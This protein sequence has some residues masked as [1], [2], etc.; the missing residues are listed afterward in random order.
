MI[1]YQQLYETSIG[2]VDRTLPDFH[3]SNVNS[4]SSSIVSSKVVDAHRCDE[5]CLLLAIY[6]RLS[7]TKMLFDSSPILYNTWNVFAN[8]I[9]VEFGSS[10]DEADVYLYMASARRL[11]KATINE[12]C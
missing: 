5:K 10:S 12:Y 4:I 1:G 9:R 6:S 3:P 11:F 2:Q 7:P 8:A